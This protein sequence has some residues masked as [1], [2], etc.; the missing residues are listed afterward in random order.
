M[1]EE[2]VEPLTVS[3]RREDLERAGGELRK[4]PQFAR[5]E[6]EVE[7]PWD[8]YWGVRAGRTARILMTLAL[9]GPVV[10]LVLAG[11]VLVLFGAV[12]LAGILFLMFA[13]PPLPIARWILDDLW[14]PRH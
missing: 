11:L 6:I 13:V 12:P 3:F 5:P 2:T 10:F 8:P 14:L 7:V 1:S 9:V 4:R